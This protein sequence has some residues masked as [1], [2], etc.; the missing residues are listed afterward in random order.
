MEFQRFVAPDAAALE[1]GMAGHRTGLAHA[2]RAGDELGILDHTADL[3]SLLTTA[4]REAEALALLHEQ[5]DRVECFSASEV[6]GWFW[7]A[8][9]T[10]LQYNGRRDDANRAF[11]RALALSRARGW[12]RLQSFVL[13]H[14]GRCLAEQGEFDQS[15]AKFEEALGIRREL[16]DPRT[17]STERAL[18]GLDELRAQQ[19]RH[20]LPRR[21]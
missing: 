14:W 4:R 19:T 8:Y 1:P 3:A 21:A 10:A 9:A 11:D 17:A 12:R 15:Q 20:A 2:L 5:L 7:N 13:Q 18:A 6:S 16:N